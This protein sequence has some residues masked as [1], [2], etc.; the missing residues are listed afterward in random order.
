M[1]PK[2]VRRRDPEDTIA[3]KKRF[4]LFGCLGLAILGIL[5]LLI[6]AL[7]IHAGPALP[8]DVQRRI[9]GIEEASQ[10]HSQTPSTPEGADAARSVPA[11]TPPL[12]QQLAQMEYA[13]RAGDTRPQTL[14][15]TDA[16]LNTMLADNS[17]AD[18]RVRD[19]RAYFGSGAA[20]MVAVADWK[21]QTLTVTIATQPVIVNGG[22]QFAVQNVKVG[23]LSAPDAIVERVQS[24][25][26]KNSGRFAPER[27]GLYVEQVEVRD[28]LAI[29]SGHAVRK[30]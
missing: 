3:R 4:L 1:S 12:R 19:V 10:A 20:Y 5:I 28:G 18:G 23:S 24:A 27:T 11:G 17:K 26:A 7:K 22:L 15:V 21:G 30:S 2:V 6:I 29:L 16:E 14:Y 9:R 8:A 25:V 13:G